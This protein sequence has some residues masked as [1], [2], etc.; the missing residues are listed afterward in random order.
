MSK[1]ALRPHTWKVQGEVPHK[2]YTAWV[3]SRAQAN[4]RKEIWLL[5]F[6]EYQR[7]WAP[8]WE[9]RG[10]GTDDYVMTRDDHLG[11][12]ALGNVM[13]TRRYDYLKRQREYRKG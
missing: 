4:Y 10:R 2:Q 9:F 6:E 7:L 12:W 11:A 1:N 5:S 3:K 13:V 8:Y